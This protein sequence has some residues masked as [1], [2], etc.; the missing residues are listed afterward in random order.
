MISSVPNEGMKI[1]SLSTLRLSGRYA[2]LDG[3]P[4]ET[5]TYNMRLMLRPATFQNWSA[6]ANRWMKRKEGKVRNFI[7]P[8]QT[9]SF[10]VEKSEEEDN[11]ELIE[12]TEIEEDENA[13]DEPGIRDPWRPALSN[14]FVL[15]ATVL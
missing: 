1:A 11:S 2:I 10:A 12:S 14:G 6:Q 5:S 3:S 7:R 4:S 13:S 15:T 9:E 8:K